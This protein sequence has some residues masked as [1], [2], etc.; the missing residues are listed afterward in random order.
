MSDPAARVLVLFAHPSPH[1]SRVYSVLV[2]S[3]RAVDGITV[4][5][6]YECYPDQDV[7]VEQE[8]ALL[9]EHDVIVLQHPFFW[10]SVPPLLKE[11]IDLVLEHGWAYG[12]R[13]T[14][15]RGKWVI[16]AI[17]TGGGASS[18]GPGSLN[19]FTVREFLRPIEQ[20]MRLCRMKYLPPFLVQG[21]HRMARPT[22]D[23]AAADYCRVL[24]A[25]RDGRIDA[26]AVAEHERINDDLDAL[27]AEGT[28]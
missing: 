20:T 22:I 13:G 17:T 2:R 24:E 26:E 19:R 10:Y 1:K 28:A 3:A 27:L 12:S 25:L 5:D 8:Q 11:W 9:L 6:L 16:S 4:R 7:Q 15:L 18:Y 14:R 21:T 23:A